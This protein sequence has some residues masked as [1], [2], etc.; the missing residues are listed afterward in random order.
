[1]ISNIKRHNHVASSV[2]ASFAHQNAS[3]NETNLLAPKSQNGIIDLSRVNQADLNN[4][5]NTINMINHGG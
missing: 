2:A 3:A 1:M 5:N 4:P